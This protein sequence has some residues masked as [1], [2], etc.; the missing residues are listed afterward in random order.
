MPDE[1]KYGGDSISGADPL[2]NRMYT[3][4]TSAKFQ[5]SVQLGPARGSVSS[6]AL[7]ASETSLSS[8]KSEPSFKDKVM[9]MMGL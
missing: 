1:K 5:P 7:R 2:W 6:M 3:R 9:K 8:Q 4:K